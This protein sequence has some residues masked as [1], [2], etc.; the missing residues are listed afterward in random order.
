M[1]SRFR[2]PF[3]RYF[4]TAQSATQALK[5]KA[6]TLHARNQAGITGNTVSTKD[7]FAGKKVAVFS[8][9][10]AF[11]PVCHSKHVPSYVQHF[12]D[13]KKA[14]CDVVACISV[15]DPFVSEAWQKSLTGAEKIAF[16]ADP[17]AEFTKTV[18]LDADLTAAGL[19]VRSKRYSMFVDNGEVKVLNVENSPAEFDKSSADVLVKQIKDLK[20]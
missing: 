9:P 6:V 5:N 14:G 19:G 12:D 13:L 17:A 15:N 3:A 8:V 4:S 20:K 7:F 1:I 16:L 10:G 18:G 2:T 11:T